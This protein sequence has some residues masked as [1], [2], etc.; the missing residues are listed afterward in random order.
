MKKDSIQ[1]GKRKS[2]ITEIIMKSF[3]RSTSQESLDS[4]KS[5]EKRSSLTSMVRN[6]F[7]IG[8]SETIVP[9]NIPTEN[10]NIEIQESSSVDTYSAKVHPEDKKLSVSIESHDDSSATWSIRDSASEEHTDHQP[11]V[12]ELARGSSK[13]IEK[14]EVSSNDQTHESKPPLIN[15]TEIVT[16]LT[17]NDE[18]AYLDADDESIG[19]I[20]TEGEFIDD[21]HPDDASDETIDL[22]AAPSPRA[23]DFDDPGYNLP[24]EIP[25][26]AIEEVLNKLSED[27][28]HSTTCD[29]KS[30]PQSPNIVQSSAPTVYGETG[31]Y[32]L[33]SF[34]SLAIGFILATAYFSVTG[35]YP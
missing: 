31:L 33:L 11:D 9:E 34:L 4:A 26:N 20:S 15:K 1:E 28:G 7:K 10:K 18:N 24:D 13:Y 25:E 21:D 12:I 3:N 23:Y 29:P 22:S 14:L 5:N 30:S 35:C 17:L 6:S 16:H 8:K 2:V 32:F 27:Q 19:L